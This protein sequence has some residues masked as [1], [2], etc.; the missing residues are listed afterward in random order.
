MTASSILQ[1]TNFDQLMTL[2]DSRDSTLW[3]RTGCEETVPPE[4][5]AELASLPWRAVFCET[6]SKAFLAALEAQQP[7]DDALVGRRG[8]IYVIAVDPNEVEL[9]KRCLP[10]YLLS[11]RDVVQQSK[12]AARARRDNMLMELARSRVA[13]IVVLSGPEPDAPSELADVWGVEEFVPFVT[14]VSANPA[15]TA[16]WKAFSETVDPVR[17]IGI[18]P[19]DVETFSREFVARYR[20]TRSDRLSVRIRNADGQFRRLD[21]TAL[22]DPEFPLLD[23]YELIAERDLALL[24]PA[25]LGLD[26]IERFLQDVTASWRPFAAGM[27]WERDPNAWPKVRRALRALDRDEDLSKPRP[28][29]F[30][31]L[32]D[33][34]GGATTLVRS[35]AFTAASEGY[36]TLVAGGVPFV[37]NAKE[38]V[39]FATR[40]LHR[41]E[42]DGSTVEEPGRLYE[43]PFVIVFDQEHWEGRDDDLTSFVREIQRSGR[44]AVVIA[45][46]GPYPGISM[47][48][49]SRFAEL[50]NLT[51]EISV[52]DAVELGRHLNNYLKHHGRTRTENDWRSFFEDSAIRP[53]GGISTFWVALSFWIQ[54]QFDLNETVQSWIYRRFRETITEPTISHAIIRIAALSTERRPLPEELLPP[55][56]DWPVASTL[57]DLR[58]KLAPLGLVRITDDKQRYWSLLHDLLGR[59]L[60]NALFYDPDARKE[61]GFENAQNP[62]HLRFLALKEISSQPVLDR[63]SLRA[64]AES[65]AVS[66]FKIDPDHGHSTL[67]PYWRDVL[68]ALDEMP[69]GIRKASRTFLHHTAVSRRRIA[70]DRNYFPMEADERVAL[71]SRAVHDLELALKTTVT[72]DGDT[73]LNLYNSLGRAYLD[74][75]EAE[76]ERGADTALVVAL[77]LRATEAIQRAYKINPDNSYVIE[78]RAKDLITQAQA[79]R[80]LAA[81]NA[82]AVL[83]I[84]YGAMARDGAQARR[85]ALSRFAEQALQLLMDAHLPEAL[86]REPTTEIEALTRALLALRAGLPNVVGRDLP[87]YP[88]ANRITAAEYLTHESL[89][90]NPQAIALRYRLVTLDQPNAFDTQLELLQQLVGT[91][92]AMTPQMRLDYALLL[93]QADRHNEASRE[94]A[95]LRRLWADE[96]AQHFG[97]VPPRLHWLL[98]RDRTTR[99]TVQARIVERGDGRGRIRVPELD[100]ATIPFRPKEFPPDA[101]RSASLIRGY[102]SFGHNGP[103]LRPL[104]AS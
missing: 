92:S 54:R 97:E 75:V 58:P 51:H 74:L 13:S 68:Q 69:P 102:I 87:D 6:A 47:Y 20:D 83:N 15:A 85:G 62:E 45:V 84:A 4:R 56:E 88:E 44:R 35:I 100:N 90:G 39:Q 27:A 48:G 78:A 65:F 79:D 49:N 76:T 71:L 43:V 40:F 57:S 77:R 23:R 46:L 1:T 42:T 63:P 73:D 30:Y 53:Q 31:V 10:I 72:A 26:E 5:L 81:P 64:I 11:G 22:D 28:N 55:G 59:Y 24:Q 60:L 38:V 9:P 33:S 17:S 7:N 86:R 89:R 95:S 93:H 82:I 36:P 61:A 8:L 52:S 37:P 104:T 34:G 2:L 50:S 41:V 80:D 12:L 21:A 103:F 25:D 91:S 14:A 66:I 19:F 101:V 16:T 99:R 98:T 3:I 29:N 32:S 70:S 18:F 67:V 94:F 96:Q